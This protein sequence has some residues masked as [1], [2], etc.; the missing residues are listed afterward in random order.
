MEFS[1]YFPIWDKLTPAQQQT[2]EN[3]AVFREVEKGAVAH[4]GSIQCTG[5]LLVGS[6]QHIDL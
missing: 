2:L 4:N 6:G 3:S 5:L 1:Q